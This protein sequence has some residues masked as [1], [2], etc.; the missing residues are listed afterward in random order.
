MLNNDHGLS[1][2]GIQQCLDL[3]QRW[4]GAAA[5][6][7]EQKRDAGEESFTAKFLRADAVFSSPLTRA[8]QTGLISLKGHPGKPLIILW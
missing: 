7:A 3:N 5:K 4:R 6:A 8:I 2:T 1:S